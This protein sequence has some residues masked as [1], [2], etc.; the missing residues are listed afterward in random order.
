MIVPAID[1]MDGQ[2]V[3][4]LK[5]RFDAKTEYAT[6]PRD[7][8]LSY[9]EAGAEWMHIV[10]LDGAKN[11][12]SSQAALISELAQLSGLKVQAGGGIRELGTIRHLLDAGVDRVVIGSLAVTQPIMVRRWLSELGPDK[13]VLAF[14]VN[15]DERGIAFPAIKG[16]TEATET[17]FLEILDNYAGS[18]LRTIL[19]TDIG[20][21]GA[22]TGG[23]TSLYKTILRDYPTLDLITS[24]GVGTLDHVREL[25]TL[26]PYG[27]IIGRALY[28]GNFTLAEAIAC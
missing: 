12:S 16:W 7:V 28:E 26:S 15:L 22:E 9:A 23:N 20:R 14:D 1:L 13:I 21:D 2:C 24:G 25:K 19:V 27:I 4:L 5:G 6:D 10:D 3:R 8:A 11:Q 18:G 17:P